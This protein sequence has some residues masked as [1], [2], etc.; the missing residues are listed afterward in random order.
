MRRMEP[1][2]LCKVLLPLLPV[3]LI[4]LAAG[5]AGSLSSCT[6]D[7]KIEPAGPAETDRVELPARRRLEQAP[8]VRV[9]IHSRP[10]RQVRIA[11][12]GPARMDV[13]GRPQ[14][15]SDGTMPLLT[16][17]RGGGAWQVGSRSL[18]EPA[19]LEFHA[20]E[21]HL[22]LHVDGQLRRY[23]GWIRLVPVGPDRM[24]IIN[25]VDLDGY[26]AGV[27]AGELYGSWH[28]EAYKAL[29][30][31]ARSHAW[32]QAL[33]A[34]ARRSWDVNDDPS[35]QVYGGIEAETDKSLQAANATAGQVLTYQRNQQRRLFLVQYSAC[36]GGRV[37]PAEV[38]RDAA[39]IPPLAG[40]QYCNDCNLP[41]N[42]RF[43]WQGL[44]IEKRRVFQA[45]LAHDR[46]YFAPLRSLRQIRVLRAT[47][48]KRPVWLRLTGSGSVTRD[49]RAEDL[50]IVLLR[51]LPEAK[52]LYS[53]NCRLVDRGLTVE[54][55]AGRGHGHGVGLC[56]WG[57]QGKAQKGYTY[58]EILSFYYPQSTIY[59]AW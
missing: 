41:G 35:S 21:G 48:W 28:P 43:R 30:V 2:P 38:L 47:R 59:R 54:F 23:R 22:Q 4:V 32:Y 1:Q 45:L 19:A 33:T 7:E 51:H 18:A 49:I 56:Q 14:F 34:P 40:G 52:G 3:C 31:A 58:A 57:A 29:A 10:V 39:E 8:E 6:R 37:N 26:V 50:R 16:V 24:E 20:L 27:L 9:R 11:C 12:T 46:D 55:T 25:H 15:Q 42:A 36:C 53:M 13:A 17:A 5:I 44:R